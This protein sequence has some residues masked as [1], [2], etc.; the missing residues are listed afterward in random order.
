MTHYRNAS[1]A[2]IVLGYIGFVSHIGHKL[3]T[4]TSKN[5]I[6]KT[7]KGNNFKSALE[8]FKKYLFQAVCETSVC[9]A[10][11]S[12]ISLSNL[13]VQKLKKNR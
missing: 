4:S 11:F 8:N 2:S 6:N 9:E 13:E 5:I 12:E 1:L 7:N 10:C 3:Q